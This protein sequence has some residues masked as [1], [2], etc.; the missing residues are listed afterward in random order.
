M[1]YGYARVSTAQQ[2][3]AS[4]KK[5]LKEAGAEEI[6]A[7]KVSGKNLDRALLQEVLKRLKSGDT[8][9]VTKMDRIARNV[10]EGIA[11]IDSLIERGIALHVLNMGIFD[12]TPTSRLIQNI[13][14]SV[15]DWERQMMLERQREG[16]ELAKEQGKYKGRQKTYTKNHKGLKHALSLFN[17][18]AD[19]KL[20][21]QEIAEMTGISRR[22]I[23]R[24]AE[25]LKEASQDK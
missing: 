23:Y 5:A 24:E 6:Y 21:V 20:T 8:L 18:R 25:R 10:I 16:I 11:L 9:V 14:L 22:T 2:N 7:E 1:K 13:L 19:N 17:N 4:Q 12:D 15:A 3:L